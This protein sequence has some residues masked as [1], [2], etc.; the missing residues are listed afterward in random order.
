MAAFANDNWALALE[1]D[2]GGARPQRRA[3]ARVGSIAPRAAESVV[4][5]AARRRNLFGQS[6]ALWSSRGE[7]A[8]EPGWW[9]AISGVRS[10]NQ[11]VVLCHGTDPE[12]V[13]RSLAIL[14]NKVPGMIEL[15]GPALCHSKLL[16]DAGLVCIGSSPFMV[17]EHM[18]DH[19]FDTDPDVIEAAPAD[20]PE[21]WDVLCETFGYTPEMAETAIPRHL[22]NTP[23]QSAWRLSVDGRIG[24]S[25]AAV[26]IDSVLVVWSMATRPDLRH[27]EYGRRLLSTMLARASSQGVSESLLISSTAGQRLYEQLGYRVLEH[28][29]QWSRPRWM[30]AFTPS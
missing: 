4:H 24:S 25:V 30:W 5:L 15:A 20:L 23:G 2:V 19:V 29:Q 18:V 10:V 16:R 6:T 1:R 21:I 22:F 12:L 13:T 8:V 11:N 7:H 3:G 14:D 28:W 17:L 9:K 27:H 26:I